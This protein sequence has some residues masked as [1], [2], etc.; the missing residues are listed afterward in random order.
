MKRKAINKLKKKAESKIDKFYDG[1]RL[2]KE[3]TIA[4]D[5]I[6]QLEQELEKYK[7]VD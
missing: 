5:K 1:E 6:E 7:N 3:L 2:S 4:K